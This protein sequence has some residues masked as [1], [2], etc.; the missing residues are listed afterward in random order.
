MNSQS[1]DRGGTGR[2]AGLRRLYQHGRKGNGGES[3]AESQGVNRATLP[4]FP[5]PAAAACGTFDGTAVIARRLR[6]ERRVCVAEGAAYTGRLGCLV[7][8]R[9]EWLMGRLTRAF[10]GGHDGIE[11]VFEERSTI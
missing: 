2:R 11:Y 4:G 9:G 8:A 3:G 10:G 5:S 7:E 1:R 6:E